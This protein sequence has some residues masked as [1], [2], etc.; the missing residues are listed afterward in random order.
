MQF[1]K[2]E[3][4]VIDMDY[5]KEREEREMQREKIRIQSEEFNQKLKSSAYYFTASES[6]GKVVIGIICRDY[7]NPNNQ[8]H[9]YLKAIGRNLKDVCISEITFKNVLS[10]LRRAS[11]IDYIEDA[12][13]VL[14]LF[15]LETLNEIRRNGINYDEN[16]IDDSNRKEIYQAAERFIAKDTF[17]PELDRIFTGASKRKA[18]GHPVHYIIQTDDRD[19]RKEMCRTLIRAL[20]L[21]NRI[22]SKRYC[23]VDFKPDDNFYVASYDRLYKSAV[24]GTVIVR[25]LASNDDENDYASGGRELIENICEIMK[26]YRY[27]VLT[28]FC[29]PRECTK[30]KELFYENLGNTSIVE[31]KEDF[32][33]GSRAEEFLKMLAKHNSVR[34][35]KKLFAKLESDKEYLAPELRDF[36]D[37]WYSNKLKTGV[38]PQYK[39][40]VTVKREIVK[41][42]PKGSAYA[43]LM[44]MVGLDEAKKIITQALN[45]SKAQKLFFD[46]GMK[47]DSPTM[48]MVFSGNPGTAKTTV[49]RLFARI[50]KENGLLSKGKLIEVGRG[51]IVGKYVGW[52]APLIQKKFSEAQGSVLFIDEAYSLIDDRDGSFGDEAINTIVQEMENHRDNVIVIFAGYIDKMEKFMQKNPGLR[53]RIAFHIHFE[54]YKTDELCDIAR[55][56]A[57]KK[58]LKLTKE[59]YEK[60]T[61]IFD[62]AKKEKDFGNGRYVRNI[63]EKAKMAQATRLLQMDYDLVR[64]D[65]IVTICAEDIEIPPAS[66]KKTKNPI[67]FFVA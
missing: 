10:L 42:A 13:D 62:N 54:D 40:I 26:K 55:L 31:L 64:K 28:V 12:D 30:A 17:V 48:H 14:E 59:A 38:Y 1:F 44:E 52:T 63:I 16:I 35:D 49:A 9:N 32:V 8:L 67:G 5:E 2:A 60:L 29:L 4:S 61:G 57:K 23:F 27:N 53:S 47:K 65:D 7:T 15:D 33:S 51:D 39:E 46:K 20:Y 18:T 50:M 43:E 6:D 21:N 36:F 66:S 11:R 34:A 3:G 58:G 56:T 25:Y 22:H 24:G 45:Y 37:E 41:T 19:I